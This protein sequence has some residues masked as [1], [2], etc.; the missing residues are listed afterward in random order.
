M[1][2]DNWLP[3]YD[4]LYRYQVF[5]FFYNEMATNGEF[6]RWMP[7][8]SYGIATYY[9]MWAGLSPGSLLIALLGLL[10]HQNDILFLFRLSMMVDA[11]LYLTGVALLCATL[12][13]SWYARILVV[14]TALLTLS[15]WF[16]PY[17]NLYV[18]YGLPWMMLALVWFFQQQEGRYLW[19]AG[20]VAALSFIGNVPYI[21]PVY[22]W[23]LLVWVIPLLVVR[24]SLLKCLW[25][26][27]HLPWLL[28]FLLLLLSMIWFVTHVDGGAVNLTHGRDQ[29]SQK[30]TL[31]HYREYGSLGFW[32]IFVSFIL[33]GTAYGELVSYTGVVP[34]FLFLVGML[35][36]RHPLYWGMVLVAVLWSWNAIGEMGSLFVYHLPGMDRFRHIGYLMMIVHLMVI[37]AAGMVVDSLAEKGDRQ[38]VAWKKR[39]ILL[40][41]GLFL[42]AL[43]TWWGWGELDG[44]MEVEIERDWLG[45]VTFRAVSSWLAILLAA[46]LWLWQRRLL[47]SC[48]LAVGLLLDLASFQ[49][50]AYLENQR[51]HLKQAPAIFLTS[52]MPYWVQRPPY[53][54]DILLVPPGRPN[55]VFTFL[56]ER[57]VYFPGTPI[58][59]YTFAHLDP[60]FPQVRLEYFLPWVLDAIAA[61]GGDAMASRRLEHGA[62]LLGVK[63]DDFIYRYQYIAITKNTPLQTG[64][65]YFLPQ[66]DVL[67]QKSMGC[68]ADKLRLVSEVEVAGD[69]GAEK[70]LLTKA[71]DPFSR[72]VIYATQ[73]IQWENHL[74][75]EGS[76][77]E[78]VRF[79]ANQLVARV[80]NTSP[81]PQLLYYADG[82]HPDWRVWVNGQTAPLVRANGGFKGVVVPPGVSEV[83][84]RFGDGTLMVILGQLLMILGGFGVVLAAGVA[85]TY[86]PPPLPPLKLLRS[87]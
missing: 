46:G 54:S 14:L 57:G 1:L 44:S 66:K 43:D 36:M 50:Q 84:M 2:E 67:W 56:R 15:W 19:M 8:G 26:K 18:I 41:L 86:R 32:T 73:P 28:L 68:G 6:P 27:D 16:Q 3:I 61:R 9:F 11:V 85:V 13:Q 47:A 17:F 77:V 37:L 49:W 51:N 10:F 58:L 71:L 40:L 53:S 79:S 78:V 76:R 87:E 64:T 25:K 74:P 22:F 75:Q 29:V 31:N 70:E 7:Y 24:P 83:R 4:S 80:H 62:A 81:F 63:I 35:F 30:V 42:L 69:P 23:S 39:L 12:M 55:Q 38:P 48:A 34:L 33:G 82:W 21:A 65:P 20:I 72:P 52:P 59:S 45:W 60:C 5:H